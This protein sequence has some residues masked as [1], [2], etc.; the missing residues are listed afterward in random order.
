[1]FNE[2]TN[3][4]MSIRIIKHYSGSVKLPIT[5]YNGSPYNFEGIIFG[6]NIARINGYAGGPYAAESTNI[7]VSENNILVYDTKH[8]I[9]HTQ[10]YNRDLIR[11]FVKFFKENIDIDYYESQPTNTGMVML[12]S[13][14][15]DKLRQWA[16]SHKFTENKNLNS[17]YL[18]EKIL[19]EAKCPSKKLSNFY[20]NE[21]V[22]NNAEADYK[23]RYAFY[24][25]DLSYDNNYYSDYKKDY[26]DDELSKWEQE[27]D[28][29]YN[30][31]SEEEKEFLK[32]EAAVLYNVKVQQKNPG[33]YYALER[34]YK[35][36]YDSYRS[37]IQD[38]YY[39]WGL[40]N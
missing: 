21:L 38:W 23:Q 2:S 15:N 28:D 33:D 30:N 19:Y 36:D 3:Y 27:V 29:E 40:G 32:E 12:S 10:F 6:N 17:K 37:T 22:K 26:S 18:F 5:Q 35:L 11:D 8:H 31:A 13:T 14:D 7:D 16:S 34:L 24:S 4:N 9:N 20:F 25:F 1:M 39:N